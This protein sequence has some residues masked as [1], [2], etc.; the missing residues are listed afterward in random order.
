M[1][2]AR[3]PTHLPSSILVCVLCVSVVSSAR[4]ERFYP[5]IMAVRPVA[6]QAG[7]KTFRFDK[8]GQIVSAAGSD[9]APASGNFKYDARGR[10]VTTPAFTFTWDAFSRL[11]KIGGLVSGGNDRAAV[12]LQRPFTGEREVEVSGEPLS[13]PMIFINTGGRAAEPPMP[14]L[15][16]IPYFTNS[17][18]MGVDFLPRHLVVVGGSYI[19]LEFAQIFRRFGAEVTV[20]EMAPRLIAREDEEVSQAV[21]SILENEGIN[22]RL[23]AKC[24]AAE[25]RGNEIS[26]NVSCEEEP[27]DISRSHLLLAVGPVPTPMISGSIAPA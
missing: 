22:V 15:S 27:R 20:I 16:E 10:L 21:Q 11:G 8:A 1:E 2:L 12:P 23:S 17:S 14:G 13:A 25:R 19:G 7:A 9:A 24:L 26:V 3:R 5:M 6:V 18:M 4:A